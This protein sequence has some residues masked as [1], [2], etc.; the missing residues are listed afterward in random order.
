[1]GDP[2]PLNHQFLLEALHAASSQ[3]QDL[4][5]QASAQLKEWEKQTGYWTLLQDAFLERSL[6]V[7]LRWI[8][9]I[10]LKQGV[11]KY[12]RKASPNA[13]MKAEK[14]NIRARLLSSSID[15]PHPQLAVQNAVIVGKVV[16]LEYPLDWPKVF[17]DITAIIRQASDATATS[18]GTDE[19][20][21]LRLTRSL[22]ILLHVVK[23]L[24]TG[25][26]TRTKGNLQSI[27]P[28]IL[29][30]LG[31]VYVRH[32]Q[33]WQGL[34]SQQ[35][36]Q[37]ELAQ[38]MMAISLL[39]LR[40]MRRLIVA[41]YESPNRAPEVNQAWTLLGD[42]V[43]GFFNA[44]N[45]VVATPEINQ[46]LRKHVINI[47]KVFLDVIQNHQAAFALL[48]GTLDLMGRYWEVVVVHGEVLAEQSKNTVMGIN[49][50]SNGGIVEDE[51]KQ[52]RSKFR[53]KVALQGML[54][55][56]GA[57]KMI[58]N[59][60]A[61]FKYRHK[62][63]KEE[64][65]TATTLFREQLFTPQTVTHCMEVL[66]TKYFILRQSDLEG[67]SEDPEGWNESWENA[68]ESYEFM[69]RP[70]AEK[71]FNDLV[72]NYKEVLAQPLMGVFNSIQTIA[73]DD[74]LVKDAVY[75]SIGLAA[76]TLHQHLNFDQFLQETLINEI[77]VAQPGYNIIRRRVA[78]MIGQWV[79][80]KISVESRPTLYKIMQHL[81]NREDA[82]NDLVVRLTA[83]H[84][85]KRCI[86][87][88]DFR[89]ESFLPF[90]DDIFN[91]LM[92]LI[93]EAEQTET[94]MGLLDV[95]GVIV[96]RLEHRVSTYAERIVRILPPLW[97]QTGDEHLFKQ[98][99][100]S[101]L[102]K[103]VSAM[104]GNSV[105]Y[106]NM[107]IPLIRFSVEPGSG[108]QVYLLEDALEL[109]E[110]TVRATP[111][112]ASP[113]LLELFPYLI[114]CMELA[115]STLRRVLEIVDSYVLLAPREIIESYRVQLFSS[116][117]MLLGTLKPETTGI[118]T[119]IVEVLIRAAKQMGGDAALN[120]VGM[121]LVSSEFLIKI[122]ATLRESYE[123]N[124]TT[125][126]HRKHPPH[127]VMVTDYFSLLARIVL[128][129]TAWF[130]EVVRMVAERTG[131]TAEEFMTWLLE[132]WFGHFLNMG[133][134][135]QRKLNCFALTMLLETNQK[136]ILE[137]LQDLM[138]VWTDVVN[139]LRDEDGQN[140][141][142]VYWK[143]NADEEE[144]YT[145]PETPERTRR[146]QLTETDP[147]H[148]VD[149]SQL[150]KHQLEKAQNENGG[151]RVFAENW[152]VNVDHD[153][154][155]EFAKLKLA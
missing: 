21:T 46:L 139:E 140:D 151:G 123:A 40:I 10:T 52:E 154:L 91:K 116:F 107:V 38:Q 4:V 50:A 85:M 5:Q 32:V 129:N 72:V 42:H 33:L 11:D 70:C 31:D 45:D 97:E 62:V 26:L 131:Q 109:W 75:T 74:I 65:K 142:L 118:I 93:E 1:M 79:S 110:A 128:A 89:L 82:L 22:S 13:M 55:F 84:N 30:V 112:P 96:D 73:K 27:T 43:W 114:S 135:S 124:L 12:W 49:G 54:L 44:E 76:S 130:T 147:V 61:T 29:K 59:P 133:H 149:A 36:V 25:R 121:E 17:T 9:I 86:D 134:P 63:E 141:S 15:E 71:L 53:E 57:I 83:A 14:Q 155:A 102:T 78:I 113:E 20:A 67:W 28:E 153:V 35:Q 115:S 34:V 92:A 100:L 94:R 18:A 66:V 68:V 127:A 148:T 19:Q 98:A 101:I 41:G 60:T 150:I 99:I 120:V 7:E 69:I 132:E 146:I 80:V 23:E 64:I 87:E 105:Q 88:W 37:T 3:S 138:I 111:A 90:V 77:Q 137:R 24:A 2:V 126:P 122:F 144:T 103:L 58:Y 39:A 108:M 125:G 145:G 152:L 95:I 8:A 16:R 136:W 48:P 143:S 51:T 47:G 119:K 6:P 106:H 81:L 104:K 117:A 56:R